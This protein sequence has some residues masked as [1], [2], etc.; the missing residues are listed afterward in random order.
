MMREMGNDNVTIGLC[1]L[2]LGLC[3]AG[4][5]AYRV[6]M[7]TVVAMTTGRCGSNISTETREGIKAVWIR[8]LNCIDLYF[9]LGY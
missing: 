8:S 3:L 1:V 7:Y 5:E 4:F 9:Y 6:M 2:G